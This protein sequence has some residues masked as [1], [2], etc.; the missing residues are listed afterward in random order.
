MKK[1][2]AGVLVYRLNKAN[3]AEVLLVHPGGPFFIK[4]D[5]GVWSIPKGEYEEDEEPLLVAKR[6]FFEET[7]NRIVDGLMIELKPV[8]IKSGKQIS[9]WAIETDFEKS[10]ISSN[11]FEME[12][13][14]KSGKKQWFAEVDKAEW[15]TIDVAK[16]KIN[17]GQIPL[18]DELT[19]MLQ[20]NKDII[21][22]K[23]K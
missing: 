2:S 21:L 11:E 14:P 13:P 6:E 5:L 8:T 10:F 4:K 1:K 16:Q 3:E 9:A 17:E 23:K 20:Q 12:W 18:L 15:F 19:E 22:H 7:G